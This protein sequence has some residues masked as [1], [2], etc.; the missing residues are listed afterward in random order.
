MGFLSFTP[1][2]TN[3]VSIYEY[4][5]IIMVSR[6]QQDPQTTPKTTTTED[7]ALAEMPARQSENEVREVLVFLDHE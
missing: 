6:N 1:C 2:H 7:S 5:T 3:L 4:F